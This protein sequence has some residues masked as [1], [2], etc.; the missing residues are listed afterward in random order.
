MGTPVLENTASRLVVLLELC[1]QTSKMHSLPTRECVCEVWLHSSKPFSR[2]GLHY[3]FPRAVHH[4]SSFEAEGDALLRMASMASNASSN[5]WARVAGSR[6]ATAPIQRPRE[7]PSKLPL[8][9]E[10]DVA[11]SQAAEQMDAPPPVSPGADEDD[12]SAVRANVSEAT[13]LLLDVSASMNDR[14]FQRAAVAEAEKESLVG[15]TRTVFFALKGG[16]S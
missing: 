8:E 9:C 11:P 2:T 12:D 15:R 1:N 13:M 10:K 5:A 4:V 7:A 14:C 3:S 6:A 16:E